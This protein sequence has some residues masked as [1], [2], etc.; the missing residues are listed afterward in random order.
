ME[1]KFLRGSILKTSPIPYLYLKLHEISTDEYSFIIEDFSENLIDFKKYND[2][3]KS[4]DIK[5]IFEIDNSEKL[6]QC[7]F[8][9][10]EIIIYIPLLGG[11]YKLNPRKLSEYEYIVWMIDVSKEIENEKVQINKTEFFTN[12][13]HELRT[14]LNIIFSSLQ[15]LNLKTESIK[16]TAQYHSISKYTNIAMQNTY[17]LLKLVNNLIESNKITSGYLDYNPQ[18]YDIV[19]FIESI[20]QSTVE[21]AKSK[22]IE[23]IFDTDIEEKV[24]NF[25]LD[26]MERI[27]L[28]ILSNAIKFS[29]AYG[30]IEIYIKEVDKILEIK[31]SDTGIGIPKDKLSSIFD[32]FKQVDNKYIKKC[33]G[34]G[35]GLYL[36]KSL[37]EMHEGDISV[38]SELEKGTTFTINIPI[39]VNSEENWTIINKNLQDSNVEKIKVEF[40][41]IYS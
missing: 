37:V 32:R 2:N 31:I 5:D 8:C 23:I 40:S 3:D 28:N 27:I 33:E 35:I 18:N 9:E 29:K 41:D 10:E 19:F 14:P 26:K 38:E 22:N 16:E 1:Y 34:S 13:S 21:F 6:Y 36:V 24:I 7:I 20:C 11:T 39:T 15:V 30:K 4:K 17:R 12:L 25:D